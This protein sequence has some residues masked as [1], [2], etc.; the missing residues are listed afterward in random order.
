[1]EFIF[2]I[3]LLYFKKS[4]PSEGEKFIDK[5]KAKYWLQVYINHLIG[6]VCTTVMR[7]NFLCTI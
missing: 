1:M 3:L 7:L 5:E 6:N 4:W 2:A